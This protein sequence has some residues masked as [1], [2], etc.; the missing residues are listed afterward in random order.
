MRNP[1]TPQPPGGFSAS[2]NSSRARSS[3]RPGSL[4]DGVSGKGGS[5]RMRIG[6]SGRDG[7][8]RE[9]DLAPP[10]TPRSPRKAF[11]AINGAL[12]IP[13][14]AVNGTS[15]NSVLPPAHRVHRGDAAA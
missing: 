13:S 6:D 11:S 12:K 8:G 9:Y 5:L 15:K 7:V 2:W 10:R 1:T 14:L 4:P 3:A